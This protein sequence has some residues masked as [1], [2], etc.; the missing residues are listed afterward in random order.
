LQKLVELH[1]AGKL[2]FEHVVTVNMDEYVGLPPTHEQ[3]Y[4]AFMWKNLFEHIDIKPENVHILNGMADDLQAECDQVRAAAA[5]CKPRRA[6][7]RSCAAHSA[8]PSL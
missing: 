7:A 1:K 6:Q 2:S 5:C 8:V 3:S 4:H